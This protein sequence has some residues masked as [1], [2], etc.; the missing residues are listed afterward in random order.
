M[1][2]LTDNQILNGLQSPDISQHDLALKAIYAQCYPVIARY[3]AK[4]NGTK[5]DMDDIFQDAV[6]VFYRK[7][8]TI[9]F[10]LHC[11][12]TTYIYSVCKKLWL[13]QLRKQ[14]RFQTV[15]I[16]LQSI[17]IED[18]QLAILN[19]NENKKQLTKVMDQL[20]PGC[21]KILSL[22]YFDRMRMKD[23][24]P[25]MNLQS[26]QA[27]KNKKAGCMKKLKSMIAQSPFLKTLFRK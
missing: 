24:A 1:K 27:A 11:T 5:E 10:T 2:T 25:I 12:V 19:E 15:D 6:L 9:G 8:R 26:E 17:T 14:N 22:Y 16:E 18:D 7:A 23:I 3:I 4:N 13:N 20:G 21:K